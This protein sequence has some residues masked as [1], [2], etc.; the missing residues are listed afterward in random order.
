MRVGRFAALLLALVLVAGCA[1]PAPQ[2]KST[3]A[4]EP[5]PPSAQLEAAAKF[6][7]ALGAADGATLATL[8]PKESAAEH[9]AEIA[10]IKMKSADSANP[11][12]SWNGTVLVLKA[13]KSEYKVMSD[14][15]TQATVSDGLGSM[16]L[17]L[18]QSGSS[19]LVTEVDG[20]PSVCSVLSLSPKGLACQ[21][22]M[23]VIF[24]A[25]EMAKAEVTTVLTSVAQ[26]KPKYLEKVPTCMSGGTYTLDP[27]K[28]VICT[29]H[30]ARSGAW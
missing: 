26:L 10:S 13:G 11:S 4:A 5:A 25:H 6:A 1:G 2:K 9:A 8:I 12:R 27:E 18:A 16:T 29:V 19:W 7:L 17:G 20:E 23:E 21:A 30:G 14:T 3:K 28:S 24:V 15:P 22:N